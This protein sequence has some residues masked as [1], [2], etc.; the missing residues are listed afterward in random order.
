[1]RLYLPVLPL[2]GL[3]LLLS[4]R[5]ATAQRLPPGFE[6]LA[7]GHA[8]RVEVR[9]FGRSAGLWPVWVTLDHVQIEQPAQV[10]GALGLA[11]AAQAVLLPVLAA[12]LPRDS[13]LACLHAQPQPGCGWRAA[14]EDPADVSAIFDEAESVLLLFPS[15]HWLPQQAARARFH[16]ASEQAD[17]ALLH[18]QVMHLSGSGRELAFNLH[19]RAALGIGRAGHLGG[20]WNHARWRMA[21]TAVQARTDVDEVYYRHDLRSSH[22]LQVG[23]IDRRNLSSPLGGQFGLGLLPLGPMQGVRAGTTLAYVDTEAFDDALPVSVLLGRDA[24]VDVFD[25]ARLLQTFYLPAGVT[26]LDT[27]LFPPGNYLLTLRIHEDGRFVRSETVP[28]QRSAGAEY[29]ALQWFVQGGRQHTAGAPGSTAPVLQAGLRLPLLGR[30]H[31]GLGFSHT[32]GVAAHELRAGLR[33]GLGAVD[34]QGDLGLI[35]ASDGGRGGQLQLSARHVAAWNAYH[36]RMRG[37][38]C[39]GRAGIDAGRVSCADATSASVSLP[40]LGGSLHVAHTRRRSAWLPGA[41]VIPDPWDAPGAWRVPGT[42]RSLQASYTR[43]RAWRSLSVGMRASVWQQRNGDA[44]PASVDRGV[45]WGINLTRLGSSEGRVRLQRVGGEVR[46]RADHAPERQLRLAQTWRQEQDDSASAFTT[47]LGVSPDGGLDVLAGTE[48]RRPWGQGGVTVALARDASGQRASWSA[49][50]STALALSAQGLYWGAADAADAG[51][52]V[53]VDRE[54]DA[55]HALDGPAAEVQA[56]TSRQHTLHFGER[57]LLPVSGYQRHPVRVQD[58]TADTAAALRASIA[59]TELQPF[60]LPGRLMRVPV[61]VVAT[62]AY[63]G[64]ARDEAG[65]ALAGASILNAALPAL[66]D[67]GEFLVEFEQRQ[68]VLYLL[69]RERLLQCPLQVRERRAGLLRVGALTCTALSA[70]QLPASITAQPHV[71]RLLSA[72]R[73]ATPG[74]T[75][76]AS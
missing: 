68:A 75:A 65:D 62:H 69:H 38:A 72:R 60:L 32:D 18:Q 19:G 7:S 44:R 43:T 40:L 35:A 64:S 3:T 55:D 76:E 4:A 58:A 31:L 8:E 15:P 23:R 29:G 25:G 33:G 67:A 41:S 39:A 12:P 54:H 21:G 22:Y 61:S 57:R 6:D 48:L 10:L 70:A 71:Q 1:M 73:P 9:A 63:L 52:V 74:S 14:P 50:H 34:L 47:E 36:Q 27:R 30:A 37:G 56:G 66:G 49:H 17:N 16:Q 5:P 53:A 46:Q 51:V 20:S 28:F 11:E 24:R 26:A 2:L 59:S 45:H 42:T 13:Q